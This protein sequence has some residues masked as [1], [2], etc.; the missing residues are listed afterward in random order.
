MNSTRSSN[1]KRNVL[2]KQSYRSSLMPPDIFNK[3]NIIDYTSQ[4]G[5]NKFKSKYIKNV[6][7]IDN[8]NNQ[9]GAPDTVER[10]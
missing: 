7:Q 10:S 6:M 8:N 4:G 1:K 9:E 2:L 5:R 3:T